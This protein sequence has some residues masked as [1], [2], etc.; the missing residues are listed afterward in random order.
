MTRKRSCIF[1]LLLALPACGSEPEAST[2]QAGLVVDTA[3][4]PL[5]RE[6]L[7]EADLVGLEMANLSVELPWTTNA[8]NR[9]PRPAA[10]RS[11]VESVEVTGHEGFD[12]MTFTFSSDAP[13]PGYEIRVV[14]PGVGVQCGEGTEGVGADA[15]EDE[16]A[17]PEVEHTPE[18][19][20]NQF[21][22]LR[23][24]P[25]RIVDQGRRTMSIGTESYELTRVHEGGIS[26]DADDV[27]T[28]IV[29]LSEASSV[30]VLEM[31]SPQ[32]LVVDIR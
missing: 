17:P 16:D 26:C 11:M 24:R 5:E 9:S 30:R 10:P 13:A 15:G 7:T 21:L 27:V 2:A 31:R 29:G 19:A 8:I 14:P 1:F 25:A 20:G 4:R 22:V 23:L 18:L 6:A 28:W 32:R 12:R 3:I